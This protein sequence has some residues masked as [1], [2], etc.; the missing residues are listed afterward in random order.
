MIGDDDLADLLADSAD[1]RDAA[2]RIVAAAVAAG[3]IDNATAVV[4]DVVGWPATAPMTPRA[5]QESLPET[6]GGPAVTVSRSVV[7]AGEWYAVLGDDVVVLLPPAA[8]ARVAGV[9]ELVDEG[10]GFDEVLDG[11][12][13]GGLRELPGFVLVSESA[14]D[15]KLVIRGAGVAE[16]MSADGSG[17][18]RPGTPTRPGSSGTSPA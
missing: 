12:I 9:W 11:L 5:E 3:G 18:R 16:L 2:E 1:P 14:G 15:V 4:V 17:H 8:K 13:S 7:T 6:A 10:A